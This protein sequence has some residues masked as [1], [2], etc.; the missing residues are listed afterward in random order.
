M[1]RDYYELDLYYADAID[2]TLLVLPSKRKLGHAADADVKTDKIHVRVGRRP[3]V[4]N[5]RALYE[6]TGRKIPPNLEIFRAYELWLVT[7]VVGVVK[8]GAWENIRELGY[9]MYFPDKP[10]ITVYA[11]LPQ[12]QFVKKFGLELKVEVGMNLDGAV[13]MPVKVSELLERIEE[14]SLYGEVRISNAVNIIGN[15]SFSVVTPIVQAIGVGDR[16]SEWVFKKY[17]RP[18]L[19]DLIMMQV[20]LTPRH[21]DKLVFKAQTYVTV[22]GFTKPVPVKIPSKWIDL[23]CLLR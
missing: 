16:V 2:P 10:R 6:L 8:S 5:L 1:N 20:V 14:I 21:L 19:G 13:S 4:R 11:V 12:T 3:T 15:L 9:K 23:E 17:R 7:H 22:N 18:L